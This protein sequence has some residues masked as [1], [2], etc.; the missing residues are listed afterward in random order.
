MSYVHQQTSWIEKQGSI[1]GAFIINGLL[2]AGLMLTNHVV[3]PRVLEDDLTVINIP[4][5]KP[6]KINDPEITSFVPP[7]VVPKPPITPPPRDERYIADII[8]KTV[9]IIASGSASGT[10][11]FI[12][13]LDPVIEPIIEPAIPD[14]IFIGAQQDPKYANRFQPLYPGSLLRQE[15]EGSVKLRFLIRADGRVKSVK[16][17]SA[18]HPRFAAAAEKQALKKWRFIPA[19]RNGRPVEQWKTITVSFTIN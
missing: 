8:D 7:I 6:P 16:I 3:A 2:I 13:P 18:S 10:D 5:K 9:P 11:D 1:G 14:P 15:I 12:K 17:L 4:V 19:T